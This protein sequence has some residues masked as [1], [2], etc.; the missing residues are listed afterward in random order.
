MAIEI[1]RIIA[2]I[3]FINEHLHELENLQLTTYVEY[4]NNKIQRDLSRLYLQLVYQAAIDINQH[5]LTEAFGLEIQKYSDTFVLMGIYGVIDSEL[6]NILKESAKMRNVLVHL[7]D[8]IDY[9]VLFD[10][11]G[12]TLADYPIYIEQ[13]SSYLETL[14]DKNNG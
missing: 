7:Y 12:E 11:V 1:E 10:S 9:S 3:D 4:L 8:K 2:K 6:S 13:I 14:E 5:I